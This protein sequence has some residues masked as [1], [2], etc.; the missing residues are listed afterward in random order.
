MYPFSGWQVDTFHSRRTHKL[1]QTHPLWRLGPRHASWPSKGHRTPIKFKIDRRALTPTTNL[2]LERLNHQDLHQKQGHISDTNLK[3]TKT[4]TSD[5]NRTSTSEVNRTS[6]RMSS[7][8]AYLKKDCR[9]AY[10]GHVRVIER[11]IEQA[12]SGIWRLTIAGH[13][14]EG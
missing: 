12:Q 9:Y 13:Y 5:M 11:V 6:N 2:S 10:I 7:D 8:A 14:R 3:G 1:R 4:R